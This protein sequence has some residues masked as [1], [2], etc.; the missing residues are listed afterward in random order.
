PVALDNRL[1]QP[2]QGLVLFSEAEVDEPAYHRRD[3]LGPGARVDVGQ[4]SQRLLAL[5]RPSVGVAQFPGIPV[6]GLQLLE[7]L[8]RF[9]IP[10]LSNARPKNGTPTGPRW[11]AAP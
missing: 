6:G 7:L 1:L 11:H 4:Q 8:H 9:R 2:G 3:V 5:S 10:T